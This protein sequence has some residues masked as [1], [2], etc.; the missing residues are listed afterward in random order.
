MKSAVHWEKIESISSRWQSFAEKNPVTEENYFN[1]FKMKQL[2]K[3]YK[4]KC[5]EL[6]NLF[7][8]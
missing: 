4:K 7:N 3:F 5:L 8:S 6:Y 2:E 1:S